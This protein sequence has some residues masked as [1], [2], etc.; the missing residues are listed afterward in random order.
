MPAKNAHNG[1]RLQWAREHHVK[2]P[3]PRRRERGREADNLSICQECRQPWPCLTAALVDTIKDRDRTITRLRRKP[4]VEPF[5]DDRPRVP[6]VGAW[7]VNDVLAHVRWARNGLKKFEERAVEAVRRAAADAD[8]G[9]QSTTTEGGG[10]GSL[11]DDGSNP[12]PTP[13]RA[14]AKQRR[15]GSWATDPVTVAAVLMV[16]SVETISEHTEHALTS[17]T[18]LA[19]LS[20]DQVSQLVDPQHGWCENPNCKHYSS[21]EPGDRWIINSADG[22]RRCERCT[23]YKNRTGTDRSAELCQADVERQEVPA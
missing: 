10:R 4:H 19:G 9:N 12:G 6:A 18:F 20:T 21:G 7:R 15:D 8:D 17:A 3:R 11:P 13:N 5:G 1:D 14:I 16:Q 23:R 22:L 2:D